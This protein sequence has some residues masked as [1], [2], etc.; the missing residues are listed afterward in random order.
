M[1]ISSKEARESQYWLNLIAD[2]H[3]IDKNSS[4]TMVLFEEIESLKKLLTSIV[5]SSLES[6]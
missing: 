2:S 1:S 4:K 5:K 3:Y 6:L